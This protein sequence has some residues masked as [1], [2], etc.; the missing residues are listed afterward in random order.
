MYSQA[1]TRGKAHQLGAVALAI[2]GLTAIPAGAAKVKGPPGGGPLPKFSV[3]GCI[4]GNSEVAA[5][6]GCRELAGSRP[7]GDSTGLAGVVAMIPGGNG[8]SLYAV[9]NR[10]SILTRLA[11]GP[12][13]GR[14]L[15]GSCF[16][17]NSFVDEC[18]QVPGAKA[19]A[20]E[21]PISSPTGTAISPDGRSLYVT[22]GDF[23]D[24]TVARFARDPVGGELT[25]VDCLTGN[26]EAG[27]T[28]SGACA[29]IP[30]AIKDGYGSGLDEPSGLAIDARGARVYVTAGLDQSVFTFAR[31]AA[32]ALT[33]LG[34]ISS[35]PKA[36]ACAQVPAGVLDEATAPLLSADG[37]FLYVA[38]KRAGAIATFAV[39]AGG[40]LAYRRCLTAIKDK[41][42]R[43]CRTGKGAAGGVYTFQSPARTIE[44]KDRRFLYVSSSYGSIV[45]LARNRATGAL[46]PSSCISG[47]EGDRGKCALVPGASRLA[48]RS[49]LAG[50]RG[51]LLSRNGRALL[52]AARSLDGVTVLRRNPRTGRLS[53][54]ACASGDL[55]QTAGKGRGACAT[56]P[57]ATKEGVSSG[58]DKTAELVQGPGSVVYAAAARDSTV[59]AL[60]LP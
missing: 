19:N 12:A 27:P 25:Y 42:L 55:T 23:H 60:R 46:S 15:F 5:R 31:D 50:A 41:R 59:S 48:A 22:S 26:T 39:A 45:V 34:C 4:T 36:K 1:V 11:L 32:G 6:R 3:L 43:S 58:F 35:N 54:A 53:F 33:P 47:F 8:R 30:S 14:I 18:T 29:T 52:V 57:G 7:E 10:G 21:S 9:G 44:S 51:M 37:R 24:A 28:G 49:A 16:T 56:L 40:D 17:G 13:P 2:L 38:A 20:V